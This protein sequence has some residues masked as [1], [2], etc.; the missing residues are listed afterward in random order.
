LNLAIRCHNARARLTEIHLAQHAAADT[1]I[2]RS[3]ITSGR[4]NYKDGFR[5]FYVFCL[6]IC[7]LHCSRINVGRRAFDSS[8]AHRQSHAGDVQASD[9]RT[10]SRRG[11]DLHVFD[12]NRL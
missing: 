5:Q 10:G 3:A 1:Q 7:E 9:L 11:S 2:G 12:D 6:T 4:L 8:V